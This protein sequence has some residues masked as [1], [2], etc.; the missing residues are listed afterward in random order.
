[1]SHFTHNFIRCMRAAPFLA[2]LLICVTALGQNSLP[3]ADKV[4]TY[5]ETARQY[6]ADGDWQSAEQTWRSVLTLA[7]DDARAWTNLGVVLNRQGKT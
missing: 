5:Y 2:V 7:S 1:M 3:N 4:R 6:E